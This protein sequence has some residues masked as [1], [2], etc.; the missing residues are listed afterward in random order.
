MEGVMVKITVLMAVRDTPPEM[1]RQAIGSI[2]D[3][4]GAI[5]NF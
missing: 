3:R 2:R 4:P 5:S 1:L